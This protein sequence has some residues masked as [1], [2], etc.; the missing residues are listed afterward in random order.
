M[1]KSV[2]HVARYVA[3]NLPLHTAAIQGA[4][5][6]CHAA[7]GGEVYFAP[8]EYVSGTV[9]LKSRVRLYLETGAIWRGSADLADYEEIPPLGCENHKLRYWFLIYAENAEDIFIEG[10][11]KIDGQ[12][13]YFWMEEMVNAY[14]R[15]PKEQR[16]RSLIALINC[17]NL[18]FRDVTLQNSACYTLWLIG[19]ESVNIDHVTILNPFDGPN[20]DA[21]DIDCCRNVHI[22]NC[23]VEAGD[24]CIAVKSDTRLLP[25]I[26]PCEN[27]VVNN[28]TFS[29]SA[30][31]I[32]LGYEGD[33][34]MRNCIFSNIVIYDSDI[35]I[36]I[37]SIIPKS[38]YCVIKEGTVI[39]DVIFSNIIIKN[40]NRPFFVWLGNETENPLIGEIRNIQFND[41]TATARMGSFVGGCG[42]KSIEGISFRNV[43]FEM[44]GDTPA[45]QV[46]VVPDVWGGGSSTL[47]LW[48]RHV[49]GLDLIDLSFDWRKAS[50]VQ[51]SQVTCEAVSDL[52]ISGL[53]SRGFTD[54]SAAPMIE[55]HDV[56]TALIQSCRLEKGAKSFVAISGSACCDIEF[57]GNYLRDVEAAIVSSGEVGKDTVCGH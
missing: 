30:C 57:S 11:G 15:R 38:T 40:A 9:H 41:I 1:E 39:E 50:G 53:R 46:P 17:R 32:R 21:F 12:G 52:T 5:D 25:D 29:S 20:T 28:C 33:A 48:C 22:A 13:R 45:N 16:P 27:I 19:C 3:E 8:G 42:E 35:A 55:L 18:F 36:D 51:R 4:I 7:G 43:K 44:T 56:A 24:D 31:A 54:T 14:V 49:K 2:F 10:P 47:G 6:A 26:R 37:V 23:H 34:P